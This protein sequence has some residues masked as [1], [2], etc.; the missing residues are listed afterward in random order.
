MNI[1]EEQVR[2]AYGNN[3]KN[4][5]VGTAAAVHAPI[6]RRTK[7][8]WETLIFFNMALSETGQVR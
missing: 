7:E 3:I 5:P 8:P 6:Y 4:I 1:H 2:T